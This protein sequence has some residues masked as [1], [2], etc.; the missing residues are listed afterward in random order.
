[1]KEDM[2]NFVESVDSALGKIQEL[3]D[4]MKSGEAM[5]PLVD[6]I[7]TGVAEHFNYLG[8]VIERFY[9]VVW[10][11][12]DRVDATLSGILE[13][14][15]GINNI[16]VLTDMYD[17]IGNVVGK[18]EDLQHAYDDSGIYNL[19]IT[20][21]N[22]KMAM[23]ELGMKA[24]AVTELSET[25]PGDFKNDIDR[26]SR[27]LGTLGISSDD[28]K[29]LKRSITDIYIRLG[30]ID[31][32]KK[33]DDMQWMKAG[34]QTVLDKVSALKSGIGGINMEAINDRIRDLSGDIDSV[35]D[36]V[37]D[38][39]SVSTDE[40]NNRREREEEDEED[41][42]ELS[43][44]MSMLRHTS[45][46]VEKTVMDTAKQ[47]Q[48][49]IINKVE[50]TSAE[51]RKVVKEQ[52]VSKQSINILRERMIMEGKNQFTSMSDEDKKEMLEIARKNRGNYRSPT[53]GRSV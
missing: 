1:M 49:S 42:D 30:D 41:N 28:F 34:L 14:M 52:L 36:R 24:G 38:L 37:S 2:D 27:L 10:N 12:F 39:E 43:N 40:R 6:S 25:T 9:D 18:V 35:A 53:H 44:K 23:I 15:D 19:K 20:V 46:N 11:R 17:T 45:E 33:E 29:D 13:K 8:G 21:E 47:T 4:V 3:R 31:N 48:V 50:E 5:K 22:L 51:V 32:T 26:V 16:A 7:I